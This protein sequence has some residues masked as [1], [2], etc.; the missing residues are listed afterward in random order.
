MEV[1]LFICYLG[2]AGGVG[3][4]ADSRGRSGVGFFFLAALL[5][6]LIGLITVVVIKDLAA[7][8]L[9]KRERNE[10]YERRF[11]SIN[12]RDVPSKIRSS[13]P[14]VSQTTATDDVAQVRCPECRELVRADA[15]KCK[16]CGSALVPLVVAVKPESGASSAVRTTG[17]VLGL[18]AEVPLRAS[19]AALGQMARGE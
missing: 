11:A 4:L 1:F 15:R 17:S 3:A 13:T 7:E 2:L 8:N 18:Q 10:E 5:S 12:L 19:A 6:P 9:Q 14:A 16:H